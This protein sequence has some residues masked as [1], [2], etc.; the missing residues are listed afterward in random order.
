V[1]DPPLEPAP[2]GVGVGLGVGLGDGDGLGDGEGE[3]LWANTALV[4]AGIST[5]EIAAIS[6]A[7]G[8]QARV[9][10]ELA[11]FELTDFAIVS[12]RTGRRRRA[13]RPAAPQQ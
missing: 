12:A 1:T 8:S 2:V 6:S 13:A 9:D 4:C 11:D 5:N 10:L 3:A 7:D